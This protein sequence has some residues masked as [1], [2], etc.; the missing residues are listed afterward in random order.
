MFHL[1]TA[2]HKIFFIAACIS[3]IA[4]I[5]KQSE[6]CYAVTLVFMTH[7]DVTQFVYSFTKVSTE[8]VN[9]IH[10]P[11]CFQMAAIIFFIKKKEMCWKKL[12]IEKEFFL[13][14]QNTLSPRSLP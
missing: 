6:F 7:L 2:I 9:Q 5:L 13:A 4:T 1:D 10:P 14:L 11:S 8:Y 12:Q 3:R